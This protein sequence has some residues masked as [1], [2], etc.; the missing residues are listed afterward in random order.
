M[1]L[2]FVILAAFSIFAWLWL[3]RRARFLRVVEPLRPD[4]SDERG[5]VRGVAFPAIDGTRL[6]AWL[7]TP[8]GAATA[9][10][11]SGAPLV[12]LAPGLGGTKDGF[13]ESFAWQLV[14]RGV[15]ALVFD[16]RCFGASEGAPRHWVDPERHRQ[17]Y[18]AALTYVRGALSANGEIDGTRIGLWGSS[19]SGGTAIITAAEQADVRALVVQCPFLRTPPELEPH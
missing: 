5:R 17:D 10:H 18:A 7:F 4:V 15:A 16:Y 12:L 13:L 8:H 9:A 14:E 19:F 1:M 3:A 2:L 11:S 6:D